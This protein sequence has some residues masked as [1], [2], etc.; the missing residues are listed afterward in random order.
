MAA[1]LARAFSA[2]ACARFHE[3]RVR[4]WKRTRQAETNPTA[5]IREFRT[6]HPRRKWATKIRTEMAKVRNVP[7]SRG[8]ARAGTSKIIALPLPCPLLPVPGGNLSKLDSGSSQSVSGASRCH[9][10]GHA[11]HEK[12][13][14]R[15]IGVGTLVSSQEQRALLIPVINRLSTAGFVPPTDYKGFPLFVLPKSCSG[16]LSSMPWGAQGTV[17]S[18]AD[19]TVGVPPCRAR[20]AQPPRR[21]PPDPTRP[22]APGNADEAQ[23]RSERGVLFQVRAARKFCTRRIPAHESSVDLYYIS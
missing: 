2:P 17:V 4:D 5:G 3:S 10:P 12:N 23:I 20:P 18:C 1:P 8:N 7:E 11:L 22:T 21:A 9:F 19:K 13:L 6:E 15:Q 16:Q 14:Q